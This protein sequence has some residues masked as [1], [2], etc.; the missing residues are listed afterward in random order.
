MRYLLLLSIFLSSSLFAQIPNPG[1]ESWVAGNW[2]LDPEG[3]E[4]TNGQL[5]PAVYQDSD[6]YEGDFAMR[7]DAVNNGL[8]AYSLAECTF[9]NTFIPASLDFYVKCQTEFG[10]VS[11]TISFFNGENMFY[12][13]AWNSGS[14]ISEWTLVSLPLSQIEPVM[15]HAVIRVEAQVGD[16]VPGTAWISIDAMGF[17]GTL[18]N[19]D[20]VVDQDLELYPN[21]ASDHFVLDGI[22]PNSTVRIINVAGQTVYESNS[23]TSQLR[24]DVQNFASGLY[25]LN[26]QSA[27]KVS[28][29]RKLVID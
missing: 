7:V 21:P 13:E 5:I 29:S 11:V 28:T 23:P 8:G 26:V 10:G 3:W 16:L 20:M 15:T 22:A 17:E 14:T 24:L 4:T 19:D 1:F 12:S 25:I 9:P 6:S 18:S 2:Q 27:D